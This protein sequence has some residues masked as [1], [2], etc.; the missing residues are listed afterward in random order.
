MA[1]KGGN[2]HMKVSQVP[3]SWP[4]GG[5]SVRFMQKPRPGPHPLKRAVTLGA[6]TRDVL[7][8]VSYN[9][10]AKQVLVMGKV[11][12]NGRLRRDEKFPIGPFDVLSVEGSGD[13]VVLP[14]KGYGLY[15]FASKGPRYLRLERKLLSPA[16]FQLGF[17]D[18][19]TLL[20]GRDDPLV[21]AKPGCTVL[22]ELRSG[23]WRPTSFLPLEENSMVV[24]V[25][26]KN[27]GTYGRASSLSARQINVTTPD[28]QSFQTS[29]DHVYVVDEA[30]LKLLSEASS[31]V[32]K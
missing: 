17:H 7:G 9:R 5:K 30:L 15:P 8:V 19:S 25:G 10:E 24:V 12:V 22:F 21:K 23:K 18:G 16:G 20:V 28:G 26:G 29:R 2:R 13:Y 11:R 31:E 1:N 14:K 3:P 4:R 32:S 27:E 6:M